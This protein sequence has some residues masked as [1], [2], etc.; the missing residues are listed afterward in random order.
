MRLYSAV[1]F[2][3]SE[4]DSYVQSYAAGSMEMI[5]ILLFISGAFAIMSWRCSYLRWLS[6]VFWSSSMFS[7]MAFVYVVTFYNMKSDIS[8]RTV[9]LISGFLLVTSAGEYFGNRVVRS[10]KHMNQCGIRN[11][12]SENSPEEICIAKW[13]V[14]MLTVVLMAVAADRYRHLAA[15]ASA[16]ARGQKFDGI[17]PMMNAARQA[18]VAANRSLVLGNPFMNQLV[19][20]CEIA[21]CVFVFLFLYNMINCGKRRWYLLLPLIPDFCMRF[22]T[23]SRTSYM[24]LLLSII[25]YYFCIQ[26]KK[27]NRQKLQGMK[28]VQK[29]RIPKKM[30]L[31]VAVFVVVFL[32]YGRVRNNAQSIPVVSYVQMYTCSSIYGLD[33]LLNKGWEENPYFGFYTMQHI[34]DLLGIRH[35]TVR[36]W[37][38]MLTFSKD[39]LHANLYTSLSFPVID[40]GVTGCLILRFAAAVLSAGILRRFL[41]KDCGNR[42]FYPYLYFAAVTVFSYFY[43]ATG[44]VFTDFFLNPGLSVRY[45]VYAWLLVRC[46]LRP[47]R[48]PAGACIRMY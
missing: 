32:A 33:H 25:I 42:S 29:L 44:D 18:F 2:V 39:N 4:P 24:L 48:K 8:F 17:M 7:L 46:Y 20:V 19:Y 37:S 5:L 30:I 27:Q 36:T 16:Y 15:A 14:I 9:L 41:D 43:S 34:Y 31:A 12:D 6:P 22:L 47:E 1:S 40:F 28:K 21:S 38:E 45:F 11:R 3:D 23:T 26:M 35:D 10:G 13:K